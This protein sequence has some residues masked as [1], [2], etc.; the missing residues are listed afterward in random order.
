MYSFTKRFF[1]ALLIFL[2]LTLVHSCA[3]HSLVLRQDPT[4]NITT[5]TTPK[6]KVAIVNVRVFDGIRLLP[7]STVVIENG[8]IGINACGAKVIDAHGGVLLPGLVDSHLHAGFLENVMVM[9]DYGITSALDMACFGGAEVCNSLNV[10]VGYPEIKFSYAPA[11]S[12]YGQIAALEPLPPSALI[13]NQSQAAQFV[14]NRLAED[15]SY[16]KVI[17]E[18]PGMDAA[19]MATLVKLAHAGGRKVMSHAPRHDCISEALA[20]GVDFI[21]HI[22]TDTAIN[23]SQVAQYVKNKAVAVPTL[24]Q[25]LTIAGIGFDNYSYPVAN[26]SVSSL[27]KAGVPILA[28]SDATG[29]H[30]PPNFL[31]P[32]GISLHQELELLVGAGLSTAHAL[33]AATSLPA[34]YFNLHDRGVIAPGFR[35]DLVLI[36]G[37]P[38]VNISVTQNIE[39]VWVG[40]V[41]FNPWNKTI[42][43]N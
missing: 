5:Y 17:T 20:A 32:M 4:P 25:M 13:Y 14:S 31:V 6:D 2:R 36:R 29:L 23:S 35:A 38:I 16:I 39:R 9:R 12:A 27:F 41:E 34:K 21:H 15:A 11:I 19:T 3:G 10:G 26:L 28:G 43:H 18:I 42:G 22:A 37:D 30:A 24:I 33:R 7:P 40:G 1:A 8:R